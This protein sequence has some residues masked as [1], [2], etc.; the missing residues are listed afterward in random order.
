MLDFTKWPPTKADLDRIKDYTVCEQI[1]D[2]DY[3]NAFAQTSARV[4]DGESKQYLGADWGKLITLVGSDLLFGELPVVNAGSDQQQ[5]N[6]LL[7]DT[8]LGTIL[9]EAS[10][11]SSFRGDAVLRLLVDEGRVTVLEIPAYNYFVELDPD[12]GRKVLSQAIAW[13]RR[14][15]E[16]TAFLR[17]DHCYPGRVVREAYAFPS[18][19]PFEI[20]DQQLEL[21]R[22]PL[23]EAYPNGDAPEAEQETGL[24]V[25]GVWH[26][27]NWRHGSRY[28]GVTDYASGIRS[29]FDSYNER[30]TEIHRTLSK[31]ADPKVLLPEGVLD[32]QGEVK[33]RDR[34]VIE[35]PAEFSR[36]SGDN[37]RY[38]VWD[39][40]LLAAFQALDRIS[41]LIYKFSETS[42]AMFGEDKAGSIESARAM[43]FRF[44]RTLARVARKRGYWDRPLRELL[45]WMQVLAGRLKQRIEHEGTEVT[46]SLPTEPI[47]L[48]WQDGLPQDPKEQSETESL[49][50]QAGLSSVVDSLVRIDQ[51]SEA[52]AERKFLKILAEK[53]RL[54]ELEDVRP[55][56]TPPAN[57]A[58]GPDPAGPGTDSGSG[59]PADSGPPSR[60]PEQVRA[61]AAA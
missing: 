10:N 13:V 30:L 54:K 34:G 41:D 14:L 11:S 49:R 38:L 6:A 40:Q 52:E 21:K 43:K 35:I 15:D 31:H 7:A 57:P 22:I 25:S 29:L 50:Q 46:V 44:T 42:P 39:G 45:W 1:F 48:E 3:L 33:W 17:V 61:G 47:R 23:S 18:A 28:Y 55:D 60:G 8:G 58:P 2:G 51:I 19:L 9:Y 37:F 24:P 4:A 32:E 36:A 26:I 16:E 20:I 59:P 12:N 56:T 5:I 27:P 53:K